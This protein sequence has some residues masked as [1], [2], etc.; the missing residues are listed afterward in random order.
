MWQKW[1]LVNLETRHSHLQHMFLTILRNTVYYNLFFLL[2]VMHISDALKLKFVYVFL[3]CVHFW[4]RVQ[5]FLVQKIFFWWNFL[6][7]K[8]AKGISHWR[9][10]LPE[11][12]SE[13][14]RTLLVLRA[15]LSPKK[16]GLKKT[17]GNGIFGLNGSSK[18]FCFGGDFL[19]ATT[20]GCWTIT[21]VK[22]QQ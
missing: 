8:N 18:F 14:L 15:G 11:I 2:F 20:A 1:P 16:G 13:H 12:W 17:F 10:M 3:S 9:F 19:G 22:Q 4:W 21:I 6:E 5:L 7:K